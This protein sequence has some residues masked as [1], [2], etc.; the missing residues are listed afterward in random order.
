MS[1]VGLVWDLLARD[2]ASPAFL[3]V[4]GAADKAAAS[5]AKASAGLTATAARMGKAGATLTKRVTLPLA[6]LAA[7][8]VDQAAKYQKSLTTIQV[9]TDQTSRQMQAASKGLLKVS[10]DTGTSLGQLTDGLYTV[11][12]GG[13]RGA[14]A[15]AVVKA[16]AQG[17]KAENVDLATATSALTSIMA[18]YGKAL[19]DPVAAE[20]LIIKGSGLA[21]TT[22]QD[23]AASLSN[24][25]PV[26]A[27]LHVSFAQVAAAIAT[28]TQHGETAQHATE[29]L[30]NL[31]T[32]LA[33][34]NN[35]ASGA[36]QQLGINTVSVSKNLGRRGLTGTLDYVLSRVAKLNHGGLITVD[37]FKKSAL[38]TSS[39]HKMLATMNPDLKKTSD[40]LLK[41]SVSI[42]DYQKYAKDLGGRAGASA[43]QF[44]GLFKSSRGFSDLLK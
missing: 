8:S 33:G 26:A 21:K 37:V 9:V 39:L 23:F 44:L 13:F 43:L 22:M 16:A 6:A 27:S 28:M 10:T 18:S 3:K 15:L 40:G 2:Q 19:R 30:R 11:E 4:A 5:T 24:V 12:K 34:Q 20:N 41:G 1:G 42:K 14:K 38:A 17:A 32:N 36:M 25:V 7:V 31:L 35:V 29:N